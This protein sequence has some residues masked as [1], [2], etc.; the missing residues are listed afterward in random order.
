MSQGSNPKAYL[1]IGWAFP[2]RPVNGRLTFAQYETDVEQ[3]I[4]IILLT[5]PGERVMLPEFGAGMRNF[6][7]EPNSPATQRAVENAVRQ[8]LIDWE[9]RITLEGVK[10]TP[11]ANDPS[12]LLIHVDYVVRATNTFYNRVYPFYLLEGGA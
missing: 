11:G 3:A 4:Q 9:P 5:L 12:L 8:A 7:F 6:V 10:V 2:V 1:G